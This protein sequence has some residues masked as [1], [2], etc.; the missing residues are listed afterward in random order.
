MYTD[1]QRH[2]TFIL[3]KK[4]KLTAHPLHVLSFYLNKSASVIMYK[5]WQ[6]QTA[7]QISSQL[8]GFILIVRALR[9][10]S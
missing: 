5:D 10:F 4:K 9:Y 7:N 1:W 8:I 3:R 2:I 6:H